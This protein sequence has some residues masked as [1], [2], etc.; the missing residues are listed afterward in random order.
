MTAPVAGYRIEPL[1]RPAGTWVTVDDV[2]VDPA[3]GLAFARVKAVVQG[4]PAPRALALPKLTRPFGGLHHAVLAM[5]DA[6]KVD[7]WRRVATA[8]QRTRIPILVT[9]S[10]GSWQRCVINVV[11]ATGSTRISLSWKASTWRGHIEKHLGSQEGAAYFES[12][13][14]LS[15]FEADWTFPFAGW[16]IERAWRHAQS[17]PASASNE[18]LPA[19]WW[20]LAE[21]YAGLTQELFCQMLTGPAVHVVR[22]EPSSVIV[23]FPFGVE[24]G[25]HVGPNEEVLYVAPLGSTLAIAKGKP[26]PGQPLGWS[27]THHR[28]QIEACLTS[29]VLEAR[30]SPSCTVAANAVD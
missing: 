17:A 7:Y 18:A 26:D 1:D 21:L 8:L 14:R 29:R 6:A 11:A 13:L 3:Q 24:D 27:S 23:A 12:V 10:E 19:E 2:V 28:E 22:C 5:S 25:L 30:A 9:E 20:C 4:H 15:H 16:H